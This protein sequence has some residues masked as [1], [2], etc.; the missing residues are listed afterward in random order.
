MRLADLICKYLVETLNVKVVFTI[1]GGGAMYLNDAFGASDIDYVPLHHEQSVGM[2]AEAYTAIGGTL[3]VCQVTT[4]PGGTNAISGCMGAW[5][6]SRPI[7]FIS[8][9][10]E[11]FSLSQ[12]GERQTGVQEVDIIEMVSSCTKDA[13]LLTDPS[14]ILYELDRL[15]TLATTGRPGPVWIDIPL[16]I[17]NH[18]FKCAVDSLPRYQGILV[19]ER[20]RALF[21]VRVRKALEVLKNK[22]RPVFLIG[23]GARRSASRLT[24][25]AEKLS[26][27]MVFGWN[28]K[29]T[30]ATDHPL[31]I[32]CAGQF[33][34]RAANLLVSQADCLIG[35][36]YRFS[37]PQIGY[38]PAKYG[39]G[40]TIISVDV[41][42]KELTKYS[43]FIDVGICGDCSEF[44]DWF[45]LSISEG[46]AIAPFH[47]W[48]QYASKLKVFVYDENPRSAE[49]IDSF[50]F[51]DVL[52]RYL[53]S[54]MAVITDMGTSF[55]CTHQHLSIRHGVRLMTSAGLAAMGFGLPGAI[56]ASKALGNDKPVILISGDGGLM[57]NLQELQS[58]KTLGCNIKIIIYENDGYLT[59]KLMQDARFG[60]RVA[61]GK[62]SGVECPNFVAVSNAFGL[63]AR[64]I[65][66]PEDVASSL[67]WLFETDECKVL[68][69]HIDP[70]QPL[71]PRV[72]TQSTPD[73]K[74]TPGSFSNM[75]PAIDG[76]AE[77]ELQKIIADGLEA[78]R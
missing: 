74:L 64:E 77:R 31:N 54:G 70:D 25:I 22:K 57:F 6:D 66:K 18:N 11:S 9:Q 60:R 3:A 41:D 65:W 21:K 73:G 44:T 47:S 34:G 27:P 1:T 33:G 48:A 29:D 51:T 46:L 42:P 67:D 59:M 23:N 69:V 2:A 55:T 35:I 28:G 19:D 72:Q 39:D 37:I 8:G 76:E 50:D 16:D 68:V 17:Q 5:I 75:Y 26:I 15:K 14:M 4:G 32:G 38:D 43:G 49:I 53:K 7:L 12:H 20:K 63:S 56:G 30:V 13:V 58:I 10:V 61:S 40:A 71:T 78:S 52:A 36:G 24:V 45:E 62:N